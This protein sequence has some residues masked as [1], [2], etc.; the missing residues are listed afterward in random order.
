VRELIDFWKESRTHEHDA[1]DF[2]AGEEA[3]VSRGV[4]RC[5]GELVKDCEKALTRQ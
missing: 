5:L 3:I 4:S 1:S 2:L